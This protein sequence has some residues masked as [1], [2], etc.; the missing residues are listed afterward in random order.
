MRMV[1]RLSSQPRAS[2]EP[3]TPLGGKGVLS[4]LNLAASVSKLSNPLD[5]DRIY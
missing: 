1:R 4:G 3:R 2:T 5:P